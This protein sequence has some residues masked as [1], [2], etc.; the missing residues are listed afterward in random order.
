[1]TETRNLTINLPD[2]LIHRLRVAAAVRNQSMTAVV[3]E[4]IERT[5]GGDDE[6][7]AAAS[8][9]V[10]RLRNAPDRGTRGTISWTRDELHER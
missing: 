6:R 2:Q 3:R 5:L 4:S 7:E 1:M 10:Q 8:R 9:L